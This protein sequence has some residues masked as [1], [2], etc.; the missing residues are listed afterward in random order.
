MK[1]RIGSY[2]WLVFLTAVLALGMACSKAA[3][4]SDVTGEVQSKI[5]ADSGLQGKQLTVQTAGGVVTLSGTVDND[6]ERTAA[7]RYAS[8]VAG[9]KQVINDLQVV[10]PSAAAVPDEPASTPAP[11]VRAAEKPRPSTPRP[12]PASKHSEMAAATPPPQMGPAQESHPAPAPAQAAAPATPPLPPPVKKVTIP[13]GT[14]LAI[15]L[16]DPID[17]ETSQPGQT[18]KATLDSPLSVD[19]DIVLPAGYDV[20]GHIVDVKSAG[21]FAGKSELVLQLDRILVSGKSYSIQSDQYKREGNSR[22]KNTAEKVGAGAAI[23][24]IIGGIAGGGKGAAIGAAAGGGLGGGV[25]AATKGQQIKLPSETVINFSLQSSL[26][27]TP[28]D[29][30]NPERHKLEDPAP[31]STSTPPSNPPPASTPE[32]LGPQQ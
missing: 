31:A 13:S 9:V 5:N 12:R 20:Q 28:T 32:N 19:G 21:K 24:A 27:L 14:T 10:P 16:V 29:G 7:S 23:G 1:P 17:S 25:Q 11:P 4:D 3:G 6:A 8:S 30:R 26:T 18:F 2:A 15:R 22:G